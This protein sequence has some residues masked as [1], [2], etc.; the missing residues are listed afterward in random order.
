MGGCGMLELIN[1][2]PN[3]LWVIDWILE[4]RQMGRYS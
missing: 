2:K 1:A 4:N 3:S